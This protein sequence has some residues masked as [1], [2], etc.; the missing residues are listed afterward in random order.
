[1]TAL[2]DWLLPLVA[3]APAGGTSLAEVE[4][5][6]RK[7]DEAGELPSPVRDVTGEELLSSRIRRTVVAT[8]LESEQQRPTAA[9]VLQTPVV[10]SEAP[11]K[12][13]AR[14]EAEVYRMTARTLLRFVAEGVVDEVEVSRWVEAVWAGVTQLGRRSGPLNPGAIGNVVRGF[15]HQA[16][17]APPRAAVRAI[18]GSTP[19]L[20]LVG[21]PRRVG[22]GVR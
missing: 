8:Q 20:R 17:Q 6:V 14:R 7:W 2:L 9:P 1:M 16:M 15:V 12:N 5:L 11:V 19:F 18:E 21:A 22:T 10:K 3:R 4:G 13:E